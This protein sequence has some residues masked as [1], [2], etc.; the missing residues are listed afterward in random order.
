M[1]GFYYKFFR[2]VF[3]RLLKCPDLK[4]PPV[5]IIK[6]ASNRLVLPWALF[7]IRILKPGSGE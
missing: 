6:I 2:T 7:P 4:E 1:L 3:I 5:A